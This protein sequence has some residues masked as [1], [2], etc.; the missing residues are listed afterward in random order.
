MYLFITLNNPDSFH[1]AMANTYSIKDITKW[2]Q[3]RDQLDDGIIEFD[4]RSQK[5]KILKSK[6]ELEYDTKKQKCSP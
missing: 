2:K 3:Y 1:E 6:Y 5:Y 4:T